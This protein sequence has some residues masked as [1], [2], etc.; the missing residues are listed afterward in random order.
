MATKYRRELEGMEKRR[1]E[2]M[3]LLGQRGGQAEVTR[4]CGVSRPTALRWEQQRKRVRGAAWKCR[5]LGRRPKLTPT[6]K[7]HLEKALLQGAQADG[8]LN[9]LWTLPRVA[10]LIQR[11]TGVRLHP[12]H[13]WRL[14]GRMGWSIQRPARRALEALAA[15]SVFDSPVHGRA[16]IHA[17]D[18]KRRRR[19]GR[20]NRGV[21]W[22]ARLMMS[23]ASPDNDNR[24]EQQHGVFATTHWSVVAAAGQSTSPDVQAALEKLCRAYWYPL[25]AFVRR[26]G[27]GHSDAEDLTQGFL[28]WLIESKHLRVADPERG[29]FRSFLL[30]RLKHFL[31]D[32]RKRQRA[33]K[34]GGGRTT[35]FWTELSANERYENEPRD[36]VTPER[37]FDRKWA[38]TILERTVHRLR[39]EYVSASSET[40]FE[41]LKQFQ[42]GGEAAASYSEVAHRL[43]LSESAV[44]SAVFR[45]RRRHADLLRE[46]VA[47][48][49][50][51]AAEVDQELRYLVEALRS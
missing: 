45:L 6:H 41:Q 29:R 22:F 5:P 10:E 36:D 20:A 48:T 39:V 49:V 35:I 28:T 17:R 14:S 37:L 16:S 44:K 3:R 42:L 40:L 13:V 19:I 38:V 9:E 46:E 24:G 11:Q 2:G 15:I 26:V 7:Q 1:R 12:G 51:T 50:A 18:A 33:Q 4:R 30:V 21:L 27:Y 32:E 23:A 31:S 43:G 34:R 47:Q 8:F 25:Y